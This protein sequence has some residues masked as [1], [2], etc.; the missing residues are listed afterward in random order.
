MLTATK[1]LILRYTANEDLTALELADL[2]GIAKRNVNQNLKHLIEAGEVRVVGYQ[3]NYP[4][5]PSPKYS[6][7]ESRRCVNYER[8]S[9][10][11]VA[12][13]YRQKNAWKIRARNGKQIM[14]VTV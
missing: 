12:K 10:S 7:A 9:A 6:S 13:R 2:L 11:E 4:G 8:L 14:G 3:P 5:H 1:T